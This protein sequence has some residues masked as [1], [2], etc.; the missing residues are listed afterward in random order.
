MITK[1][2]DRIVSPLFFKRSNQSW[3]SCYDN[4]GCCSGMILQFTYKVL[5]SLFV[6][7]MFTFSY[8]ALVILLISLCYPFDPLLIICQH[9][10]N[11]VIDLFVQCQS[12]TL[13][14]VKCTS[15]T[16][17]SLDRKTGTEVKCQPTSL[18]P[19]GHS[20]QVTNWKRGTL[21]KKSVIVT[22]LV[23]P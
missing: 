14:K 7:Y 6:H 10:P 17:E 20:N 8:L 16:A 15:L 23:N 12:E 21:G 22:Q 4:I 9:M 11:A 5:R 19:C 18:S 2:V 3:F 13:L 1:Q